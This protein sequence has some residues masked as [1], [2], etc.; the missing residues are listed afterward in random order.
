MVG[1]YELDLRL[2]HLV[3]MLE[4]FWRG[5]FGDLAWTSRAC[6]GGMDGG[7]GRACST[8][9][10]VFIGTLRIHLSRPGSTP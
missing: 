8:I 10:H 5:I 9:Y 2:V 3:R 6:I 1:E 4:D 7:V